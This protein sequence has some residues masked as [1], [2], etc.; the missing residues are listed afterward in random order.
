MLP[1]FM[2]ASAQQYTAELSPVSPEELGD[3]ASVSA[4]F[5]LYPSLEHPL[6][7]EG[8]EPAL[9]LFGVLTLSGKAFP[10]MLAV[11]PD[12]EPYLVADM[13]RDWILSQN[14]WHKAL[15]L[16]Q[17]AWGWQLEFPLD[18][19]PYTMAMVWQEGKAYLFLIGGAP[20]AAVLKLG[21][22]EVKVAL[23]DANLNGYYDDEGY[24][25]DV[26]AVDVD[27]DGVL[28]AERD[29]H[30]RFRLEEPFTVGKRS[31]KLS[32][33]SPDGSRLTVVPT[34][35]VP[36]KP[37]LYV[38][39]KAID[40]SFIST[41]EKKISL[42]DLRGKVVL[43]DFWAS[44]CGPC[45]REL[46][47][48]KEV[49]RRFHDRGFEIIGINLDL[50]KEQ[51]ED[52]IQEYGITWP[53]YFD[54][55]GWDNKI[56]KLYR[57]T[58]IPATYLL[59]DQGIIRA[60]NVRGE[61]LA[62]EVE[63]LIAELEEKKA[64][65]SEASREE[66]QKASLPSN[67]PSL[68]QVPKEILVV[69]VPEGASLFPGGEVRLEVGL[70]NGSQYPA[71]DVELTVTDLPQGVEAEGTSLKEVPAFG[72]RAASVVLRSSGVQPG[73][74]TA[75]VKIRYHYCIGDSCFQM[76]QEAP[77]RIVVSEKA[78]AQ[79]VVKPKGRGFEP[80]WLLLVLGVGLILVW[81]LRGSGL[82]VLFL[83]IGLLA[84]AFL[85]LGAVRGQVSQ[86][87]QVASVLCT[88]CVGIE[89]AV[90]VEPSLSEETVEALKELVRPVHLEVYHAEW[91][92][93]CPYAMAMA[94]EF[95]RANPMIQ[96]EFINASTDP[97]RAEGVG[98]VRS[99]HLVVP[100]IRCRETGEV[101]T[102][103]HDLE[104]RLLQMVL[105]AGR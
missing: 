48:V 80:W 23:L 66:D 88:S 37:P 69:S 13:N 10:L 50:D 64:A 91:C 33:V 95:S 16:G 35:Y 103:I 34:A 82:L 42:K 45:V 38:G 51:F 22:K 94:R 102:G 9:S 59:D 96:V 63:K 65:V 67:L 99:G 78:P 41:D 6:K 86:A 18:S 29:G 76:S 87:R 43:L 90:H 4:P 20:R 72:E 1:L 8:P 70:K 85:Y 92:H 3:W 36:P 2:A 54:G 49:Y 27:G 56:A 93:S 44:W 52:F 58:A 83:G 30:E 74:Y 26:L 61:K 68:V 89:E 55:L 81:F 60:K 21:D 5:R 104:A 53:Q 71:E 77:L 15:P 75:K 62:Q 24:E 98:I 46:P 7:R 47:N 39:A 57:V 31:Y 19:G 17:G 73:E 14:E 11:L 28:H 84:G 105:E 40:F 97:S 100:A 79:A 25:G 12:G 32:S 101:I